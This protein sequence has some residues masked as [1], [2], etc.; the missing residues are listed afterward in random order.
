MSVEGIVKNEF[1]YLVIDPNTDIDFD[2]Q[3]VDESIKQKLYDIHLPLNPDGTYGGTRNDALYGAITSGRGWWNHTDANYYKINDFYNMGSKGTRI[4][5]EK[6]TVL[7]QT[8]RSS[9]G[10]CAVNAVLKYYGEE[11]PLYDM[12]LTYLNDYE[13]YSGEKPVKGRGS[14]VEG[15]AITLKEWGYESEYSFTKG[16]K[17]VKFPTYES[18]M[19]FIRDNL[20]E[21]RPIVV[22]TNLGSG[23]FLTVIGIDDMGTD[24]I[25]DDVL[26]TADSCDYW[27]GYQDGYNVFSAYKFYTQHTN[28]STTRMQ[29]H[30][31][32]Y[33]KAE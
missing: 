22:S 1:D 12:E 13:K 31:V 18:Y 28:S 30:I 6:F 2:Y 17:P 7:Q 11:E 4:M 20:S 3:P 24:Y 32:I 23:H 19:K 27:D 21:G 10:I 9:C 33:D 8:M 14:T 25:Y 5:L 29:S 26:I 15:H 16:G